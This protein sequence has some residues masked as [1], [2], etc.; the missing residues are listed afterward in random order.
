MTPF[1]VDEQ[2]AWYGLGLIP[3]PEAAKRRVS[4]VW[5]GPTIPRSEWRPVDYRPFAPAVFDQR[6]QGSCVGHGGVGVMCTLR[7][8]HGQGRERLSP[9]NLYGQINGGRDRGALVTD[10]LEALRTVGACLESTIGPGPW[11]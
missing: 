6:A 5:S 3:S 8:L 11:P 9:S 2:G 10:A 4:G 7:A 1:Y